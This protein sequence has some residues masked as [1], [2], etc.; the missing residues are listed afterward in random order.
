[1]IKEI[2]QKNLSD[3]LGESTSYG[4]PRIFKTKTNI[5]K[6][7][8]LI[9][10]LIGGIATVVF[11][12]DVVM[13][14][15]EYEIISRVQS[16]SEQSMPFPAISICPTNSN[17][18]KNKSIDQIL[19][20]CVFG[21]GEDC[22]KNANNYFEKK[23]YYDGECIIF[24]NGRNMTGHSIPIRYQ[25]VPATTKGFSISIGKI[26]A[27]YFIYEPVSIFFIKDQYRGQWTNY[28]LKAYLI[29]K[30]AKNQNHRLVLSRT[31]ENK[32]STPKRPCYK[33]VNN[34]TL[35]KTIIDY[36]QS[37]NVTYKQE[38][39]FELCGELDFIEANPCNETNISFSVKFNNQS[40]QSDCA[41]K[42]FNFFKNQSLEQKCSK[43]C[44]LECDST[45]YSAM[46]SENSISN[47]TE[48]QIFYNEFKY[49]LLT[50]TAKT[51]GMDLV[52][53]IGGM[54]SLFIG[55]SFVSLFEFIE[56]IIELCCIFLQSNKTDFLNRS[57]N[58]KDLQQRISDLENENKKIKSKIDRIDQLEDEF[59]RF[60]SKNR[61][62]S[63]S[64]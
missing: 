45:Y 24:N 13:S 25:Y 63:N 44:P 1:M 4:L 30:N 49:T 55:L 20:K 18:F 53:N 14:Y 34:F 28:A 6:I 59:N 39:C 32:F 56:I 15:L 3:L 33:D 22:L 41:K 16:I 23:T 47:L 10:F 46:I 9:Y 61:I 48:T 31:V 60:K 57:R 11:V 2:M 51:S 52:S 42:Y 7:F 50:E 40:F 12:L 37:N 35:N 26:D 38:Y 36:I 54:L 5:M 43:Y 64:S 21:D 8:W 29:T 19:E 27:F 17:S 58:N 62:M